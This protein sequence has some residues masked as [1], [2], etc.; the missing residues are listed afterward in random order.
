MSQTQW[1]T[2]F[3]QDNLTKTYESQ[4]KERLDDAIAEYLNDENITS[5]TLYNDIVEVLN[6][7][8][9]YHRKHLE[10]VTLALKLVNEGNSRVDGDAV[11][12][13]VEHPE[14]FNK[15]WDF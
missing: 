1:N 3:E 9:D 13:E 15:R 6:E 11:P 14:G 2:F 5:I 12:S 4:R 7:W 8:G 10:N